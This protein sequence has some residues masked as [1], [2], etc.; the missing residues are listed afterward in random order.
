MA[1]NYACLYHEYLEE[2]EALN[3]A[4]FGR[5]CRALISYSMSG[6]PIALSGN[7]RFYAKR[8]MLQEDRTQSSYK[9][10]CEKRAEAGRAGAGARWKEEKPKEEKPRR[11]TFRA[12]T[13]EEVAEYC[14]ERKNGIDQEHFVDYYSQQ[15]WK[16]S[17][18]QKMRDW[19]A[20]IRTWEHREKNRPAAK[21]K[22]LYTPDTET[23]RKAFEQ[24]EEENNV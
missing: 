7:E 8:V 13:V 9:E 11:E 22:T 17:N 1:R 16:L 2:M 6:T 19:K 4:E 15:G 24:L 18:G 21:V 23:I 20:A 12:P 10:L 5:L 3:D 14:R